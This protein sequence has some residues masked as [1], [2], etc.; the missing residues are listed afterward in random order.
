MSILMLQSCGPPLSIHRPGRFSFNH[1]LTFVDQRVGDPSCMK[2]RLD[3]NHTLCRESHPRQ[4]HVAMC[5]FTRVEMCQFPRAAMASLN[6]SFHHFCLRIGA[7][8]SSLG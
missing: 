7:V 2:M 6:A 5:P 8:M 3:I 4:E 1:L